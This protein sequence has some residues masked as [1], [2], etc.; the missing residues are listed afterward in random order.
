MQNKEIRR[1]LR[2][3]LDDVDEHGIVGNILM[4][5]LIR[6]RFPPEIIGEL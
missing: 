3:L 1:R 5:R 2:R 4:R 6:K